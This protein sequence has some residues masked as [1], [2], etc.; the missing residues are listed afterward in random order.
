[1]R[2]R[3]KLWCFDVR[4]PR[5]CGGN[6]VVCGAYIL[7]CARL[8]MLFGGTVIWSLAVQIAQIAIAVLGASTEYHVAGRC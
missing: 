1:M 4:E 5:H 7:G 3:F 2:D 8:S 6:L